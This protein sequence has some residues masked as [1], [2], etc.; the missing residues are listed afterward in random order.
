MQLKYYLEQLSPSTL[1]KII[2]E[3]SIEVTHSAP[4]DLVTLLVDLLLIKNPSAVFQ[5]MTKEEKDVLT[6][7]I[8]NNP[9]QMLLYRKLEGISYRISRDEFEYG[10]TKLRRK[11]IIFTLRK[12]WG[13]VGFIIPEDLY[14]IWHRYFFIHMISELKEVKKEQLVMKEATGCLEEDLFRLLTYVETENIPITQKGTIHKRHIAK[15]SEQLLMNEANLLHFPIK[16]SFMNEYPKNVVLLLEVANTIELIEL[17]DSLT[18]TNKVD[19]WNQLNS[20]ERRE[21]LEQII[22]SMFKSSDILLTHLFFFIF[23]LPTEKWYSLT[24]A[25]TKVSKFLKRPAAEEIINRAFQEIMIPLYSIGWLNLAT[26]HNNQH[27]F[28]WNQKEKEANT[29]IYVQPNFELLIP[30]YFPYH[31]RL[32]IEKFAKIIQLDKMNRYMLTKQSILKGLEYG[33]TLE[34]ILE[35][36]TEYSV[37]PISENVK[38]T[39]VDWTKNYG[40][41]SF[42]DVRILQCETKEI[43]EILKQ[44]KDIKVWIIGEISPT[45]LIVKKN[46]FENLLEKLMHMGY[47][48][49]KEIWTGRQ[50][51]ELLE[52]DEGLEVVRHKDYRIENIFPNFT[53]GFFEK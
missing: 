31:L 1:K 46:D 34:T 19:L 22:R 39:L 14:H 47:Q 18:V 38:H 12:S 44:Q 21:S 50:D 7:L 3:H 30:R 25:L 2:E 32:R 16:Q 53:T 52:Y 29:Q 45:H 4:N 13:E 35:L 49:I 5:E 20:K 6:Y 40:T 26:D 11:G 24:E 10:L 41:I 42:M 43:A 17:L 15:I 23:H 28:L 36:L 9:N 37:I 48:P 27:Y 33:E 51:E 8:F